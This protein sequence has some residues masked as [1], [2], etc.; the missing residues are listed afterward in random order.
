MMSGTYPKLRKDESLSDILDLNFP[1]KSYRPALCL[2]FKSYLSLKR[3]PAFTDDIINIIYMDRNRS[4]IEFISS[5]ET[6][7]EP[8]G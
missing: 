4:F 1:N 7:D 8:K 6:N 2:S 5:E 3:K